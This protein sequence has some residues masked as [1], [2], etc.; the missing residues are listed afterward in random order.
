MLQPN[1][2]GMQSGTLTTNSGLRPATSFDTSLLP[3]D[4]K[5]RMNLYDGPGQSFAPFIVWSNGWPFHWGVIPSGFKDYLRFY[6]ILVPLIKSSLDQ[7]DRIRQLETDLQ[8][9]QQRYDQLYDDHQA[10]LAQLEA[11]ETYVDQQ[12][13]ESRTSTDGAALKLTP[14]LHQNSPNPFRR[15]TSIEYFVPPG[16]QNASIHISTVEGK[17]VRQI[18]LSQ[19]GRSILHLKTGSFPAGTYQY[20]LVIDGKLID[21]KRMVIIK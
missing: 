17:V 6:P 21:T 3:I 4:L 5:D 7:Q 14:T 8:E 18:G 2:L 10:L 19:S 20:S 11:L 15:E 1:Q 12:L 9:T 13:V 16:Y